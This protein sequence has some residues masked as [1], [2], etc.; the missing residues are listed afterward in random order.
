MTLLNS[1]AQRTSTFENWFSFSAQ[2]KMNDFILALEEGWRVREF[3]MSRQN[4]TDLS[5]E[6]KFSKQFSVSGGYRLALKKHMFS[7]SEANN[8]VYID[9]TGS[10]KAGDFEFS[11]REKFQYTQDGSEDDIKLGT[12]TYLRNRLK[13]KYNF[14]KEFHLSFSYETMVLM[15]PAY[16]L[17]NENRVTF[18]AAYRFNKKNSLSLAYVFR[19][20]VQVEDPLNVN[21]ISLD[22]VIKL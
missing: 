10:L 14:S 1:R 15:A 19:S 8:R 13:A 18:E 22:Y 12:E 7:I 11:L 2:K 4:Y 3:Y 17:I 9:A 21:V 20:Y 5:L 16:K 6:Y